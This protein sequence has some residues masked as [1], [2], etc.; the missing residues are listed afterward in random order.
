LVIN[1]VDSV[2]LYERYSNK[3]LIWLWYSAW[4]VSQQSR[5]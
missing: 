4:Q 2:T 5:K 1:L 3:P